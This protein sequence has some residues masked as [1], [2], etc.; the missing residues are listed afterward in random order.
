MNHTLTRITASLLITLFAAGCL[1]M[2]GSNETR[3]G[4]YV[5]P[6][7]FDQIKP[8][9]TTEAWVLATLGEPT[10]KTKADES[11]VWK[12]EYNEQR[13]SSGAIFLI[14]GGT[15]KKQSNGAA[16][17]ELKNGVVTNAWRD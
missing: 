8:G 13:E 12:W 16:Y 7:T 15:S 2:S 6:A 3:T 4:K 5:A 9:K 10:K 11:E 14:F 1:V 17:V